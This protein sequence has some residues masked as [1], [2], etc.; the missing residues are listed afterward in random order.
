MINPGKYRYKIEFLVHSSGQDDYGEP[1]D[2]WNVLKTAW[3]SKNPILGNEFYTALTTDSKVEIK[4]NSRYIS[5]I[6]NEMR[7]KH[8]TEVYEILS[9]IDVNSLHQELLC[10]CKL[11]K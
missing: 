3:A 2:E 4:F 7:I 10:Y 5:G 8:G 9:A 6:T 1:I 11:V